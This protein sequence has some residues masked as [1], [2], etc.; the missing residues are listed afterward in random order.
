MILKRVGSLIGGRVSGVGSVPRSGAVEPGA[1]AYGLDLS[2]MCENYKIRGGGLN[3]VNDKGNLTTN[4]NNNRRGNSKIESKELRETKVPIGRVNYYVC[5]IYP[6]LR[7]QT[8]PLRD[9]I[10]D[11]VRYDEG[12]T[13][14]FE[15]NTYEFKTTDTE[16][17]FGCFG[18]LSNPSDPG[19]DNYNIDRDT[20][21]E[22]PRSTLG[23]TKDTSYEFNRNTYEFNK[24][25]YEF[26]T[27]AYEFNT[28]T[29]EFNTFTYEFK[30]KT[31]DFNKK[32]YEF[33]KKTYEFITKA[34]E[35]IAAAYEFNTNSEVFLT[36]I[37]KSATNSY[38]KLTNVCKKTPFMQNIRIIT[39][40]NAYLYKYANFYSLYIQ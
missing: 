5:N 31:Y 14:E 33:G 18:K 21:Y 27:K 35:F 3:F 22:I 6:S 13:C 20:Y 9:E 4:E 28:P 30:G 12:K 40:I 24:F 36:N 11:Q 15:K 29:Y 25:T 39:Q 26:I 37:C 2:N 7:S 1:G 16:G 17:R 23:M 32:T 19:R 8:M 10:P 34:Y 38:A